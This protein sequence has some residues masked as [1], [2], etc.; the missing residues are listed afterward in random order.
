[1]WLKTKIYHAR[2]SF[3]TGHEYVIKTL[4]VIGQKNHKMSAYTDVPI[5]RFF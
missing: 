1:M 4:M 3:T 5:E 2:K